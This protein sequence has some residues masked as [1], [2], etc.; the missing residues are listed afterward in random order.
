MNQLSRLWSLTGKQFGSSDEEENDFF[1]PIGL[2]LLGKFEC[3]EYWCTPTNTK[4]F[5]TTGGD[6]VHFGIFSLPGKEIDQSPVVM[7]LP[8]ADESNIVVAE[9][10]KEFLSLGCR[11]GFFTLEQIEYQGDRHISFLEKHEYDPE[12]TKDEIELLKMIESA[13]ELAP[14]SRISDRLATLKKKYYDKLQ[15]SDE[16]YEIKA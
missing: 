14:P 3:W 8:C 13:F 12:A 16:Y 9:D 15:Y 10:F 11:G 5:A 7:T 4:T 2:I 1:D 6:G